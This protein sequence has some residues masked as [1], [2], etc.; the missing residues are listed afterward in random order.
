[1][2]KQCTVARSFAENH[3]NAVKAKLSGPIGLEKNCR[4]I[5]IWSNFTGFAS[6]LVFIFKRPIEHTLNAKF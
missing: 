2:E 4:R 6:D 1:M 5:G 3:L